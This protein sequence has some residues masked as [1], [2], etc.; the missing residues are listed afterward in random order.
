MFLVAVATLSAGRTGT[1]GVLKPAA[2]PEPD[3]V[4]HHGLRPAHFSHKHG[5]E[6]ARRTAQDE[7][8][9]VHHG[10]RPAHFAHKHGRPGPAPSPGA[11]E[12]SDQL[13]EQADQLREREAYQRQQAQ[14]QQQ[15]QQLGGWGR[16]DER[17]DHIVERVF[18]QIAAEAAHVLRDSRLRAE[19]PLRP[20]CD[21]QQ[22]SLSRLL[23]TLSP[24]PRHGSTA[25]LQTVMSSPRVH[26]MCS[27]GSWECET[28]LVATQPSW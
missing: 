8:G 12:P 4:V 3:E 26:T 9:V 14:Q 10:R 7:N 23:L 22:A 20:V 17:C 6:A 1:E 16:D 11:H 18:D 19:Q 5:H 13:S 24:P 2:G 21:P 27:G 28:Q 15:Q 25:L